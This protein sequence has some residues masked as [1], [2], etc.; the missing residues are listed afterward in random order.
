VPGFVRLKLGDLFDG[1][2]DL[3]VLPCSTAGTITR[4]VANRLIEY[5]IPRPKRGMELGEVEI[6]PFSGAENIAQYVAFAASVLSM[7]SKPDAIRKI[8]LALGKFSFENESVRTISAP[9]LGAGA[10]G[11]RSETVVDSLSDGFRET[12]ASGATLTIHILHDSVYDRLTRGNVLSKTPTK[13]TPPEKPIRVFIS[14]SGTSDRHRKWVAALGTFLR[15]NGLNARLDQW[16]LRKGMEGA[17]PFSR[18][19]HFN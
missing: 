1:P 14:Y 16:H 6:M 15:A 4:F 13:K 2:A 11:L 17:F 10:G 18:S 12:A 5:T 9:L 8:G 3:I 7:T 19:S